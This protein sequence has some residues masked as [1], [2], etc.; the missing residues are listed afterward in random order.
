MGFPCTRDASRWLCKFH[1]WERSDLEKEDGRSVNPWCSN[2]K[3][4]K[5]FVSFRCFISWLFE[6]KKNRT[7]IRGDGGGGQISNDE[8]YFARRFQLEI[9]LCGPSSLFASVLRAGR[10]FATSKCNLSAPWREQAS[11]SLSLSRLPFVPNL[12]SSVYFSRHLSLVP[13]FFT[14]SKKL[15][16]LDHQPWKVV[17]DKQMETERER[18]RVR[19]L[20][21]KIKDMD[22][23]SSLIP[24]Q[25][26]SKEQESDT[27]ELSRVN[28]AKS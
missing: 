21:K 22:R 15:S 5:S 13:L 6:G 27:R 18:E 24:W 17:Y 14:F 9:S 20:E 2:F 25:L 12:D 16:C 11:L 26:D 28:R 3:F 4:F 1:D 8:C 19:R 7:E 10:R 23:V